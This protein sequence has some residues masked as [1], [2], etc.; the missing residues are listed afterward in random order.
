[1]SDIGNESCKSLPNTDGLL[2]IDLRS[3]NVFVKTL[4]ACV[5]ST[6][7]GNCIHRLWHFSFVMFISIGRSLNVTEKL[8]SQAHQTR[9]FGNCIRRLLGRL[10]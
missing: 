3:N 2:V 9:K 6:A 7:F 4:F 1:M 10:N 5:S 8:Q